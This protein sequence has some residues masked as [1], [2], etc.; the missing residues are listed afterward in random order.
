MTKFKCDEKLL[1]SRVNYFRWFSY[2]FILT[3][4]ALYYF[5]RSWLIIDNKAFGLLVVVAV[6]KLSSMLKGHYHD[7]LDLHKGEILSVNDE[8]M[9]F[10]QHSTGYKFE[11][12]WN[13][14]ETVKISSFLG[15]STVKVSFRNNELYKFKWFKDAQILYRELENKRLLHRRAR[16]GV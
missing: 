15:S 1:K 3:C 14:I 12:R 9:V 6:L 11:K 2:L 7:S 13:E 8:N 10:H 4:I 16:K 5:D